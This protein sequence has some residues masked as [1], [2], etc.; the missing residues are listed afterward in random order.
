M[1]TEMA[2]SWKPI[3][4]LAITRLIVKAGAE[5]TPNWGRAEGS[6]TGVGSTLPALHRKTSLK[7]FA[8]PPT[9][10]RRH[11]WDHSDDGDEDQRS[12]ASYSTTGGFEMDVF[13]NVR[14]CEV[15]PCA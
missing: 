5:D 14:L 12:E 10:A 7:E 15:L 8:N 3:L 9:D 13:E 4:Y 11:G 2:T 6:G 1:A